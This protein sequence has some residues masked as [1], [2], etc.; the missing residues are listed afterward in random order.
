M[1][2]NAIIS[3]ATGVKLHDYGCSL[4]VF[5]A[6][7][8]KPM[9]LYGEMHRFL[10]AIASEQGV[11]IVE[12]VVNHRPRLHGKSK[13][14]ISRT[15]RVVL[16]L[17]TVKFLSSYSTRPLQMFGSLGVGDGDARHTDRAVS[18]LAYVKLVAPAADRGPA[19]C[20][21]SAIS[22]DP[23]R[24]AAGHDRPARRD[25]VAHLPRV[26]EQAHLCHPRGRRSRGH[27]APEPRR[28]AADAPTQPRP[29]STI[30]TSRSDVLPIYLAALFAIVAAVVLAAC[31]GPTPTT[32]TPPPTQQPAPQNALP[33][34]T[35][36]TAQGRRTRQPARFADLRETLDVAAAVRDSETSVDELVYQWSATAGT[37][38]RY[39]PQRDVDGAGRGDDAWHRHHHAEGG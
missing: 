9:R 4:K 11:Q 13:Y 35:A 2:A 36:I 24:R 38:S 15:I 3:F 8:V 32:P 30:H 22:A 29:G 21:C 34:S 27:V 37:F 1:I 39:R 25:A 20:C 26:A 12:Q 18:R 19:R 14:G 7:V 17:M 23:R 10:P 5:R 31:S 33:R 16:D 28:E 6:E